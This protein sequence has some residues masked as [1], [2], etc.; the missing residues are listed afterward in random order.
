MKPE[1]DMKGRL[2]AVYEVVEEERGKLRSGTKKT[3]WSK[4]TMPQTNYKNPWDKES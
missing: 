2:T 1:E 3:K 4:W